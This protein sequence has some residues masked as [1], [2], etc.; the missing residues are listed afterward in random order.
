MSTS[1]MVCRRLAAGTELRQLGLP[2]QLLDRKSY[3]TCLLAFEEQVQAQPWGELIVAG[4]PGIGKSTLL[5]HVARCWMQGSLPF[6]NPFNALHIDTTDPQRSLLLVQKDK[7]CLQARETGQLPRDLHILGL[8][9]MRLIDQDR[10]FYVG[11]KQ[12]IVVSSP[13]ALEQH[14]RQLKRMSRQYWLPV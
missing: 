1:V 12:A 7:V 4:S 13:G 11:V 5:W 14:G 10:Q 2:V 9:E 6:L 8:Y 3:K